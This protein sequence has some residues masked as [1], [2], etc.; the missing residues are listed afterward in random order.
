MPSKTVQFGFDA[1]MTENDVRAWS[2]EFGG[3]GSAVAADGTTAQFP[4][5]WRTGLK[6]WYDA[7]WSG[8]WIPAKPEVDGIT[9][10]ATDSNTFQFGHT[11]MALG[12]QWYT[13][14]IYPGEGDHAVKDWDIAVLP[15][16][17]RRQGDLEAPRRHHRHHGDHGASRRRHSRS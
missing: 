15:G 16:G 11:A 17:P 13:C 3:S 2:T 7:V 12:H 4:D 10:S 14:C 5:N 8:G 6:F 9:G 1:H